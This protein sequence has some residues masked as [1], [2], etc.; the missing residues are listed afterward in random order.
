MVTNSY[1]VAPT[2]S[3]APTCCEDGPTIVTGATNI[4]FENADGGYLMAMCDANGGNQNAYSDESCTEKVGDPIFEY[5]NTCKLLKTENGVDVYIRMNTCWD[6]GAEVAT[7]DLCDE[8]EPTKA[9]TMADSGNMIN[10][11]FGIFGT[12]F[13]IICQ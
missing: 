6:D 7:N 13:T 10:I 12:V 9:P 11:A 3:D 8:T 2:G 4:C 5:D 1:L